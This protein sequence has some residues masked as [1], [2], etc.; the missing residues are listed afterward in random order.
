MRR[1]RYRAWGL[2][3]LSPWMKEVDELNNFF[4]WKEKGMVWV[5]G[6]NCSIWISGGKNSECILMEATWLRD[7]NDFEIFE[8]DI[9]TWYKDWKPRLITWLKKYWCFNISYDLITWALDLD[10]VRIIWNKYENE[11][12]LKDCL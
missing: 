11:E 7:M 1:V 12:L 5:N 10:N 4:S 8:D 6:V 3:I 2:N 9:I